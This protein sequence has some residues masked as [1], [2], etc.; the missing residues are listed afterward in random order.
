MS[1]PPI[2]K[3]QIIQLLYSLNCV[4]HSSATKKNAEAEPEKIPISTQMKIHLSSRT[5]VVFA[6]SEFI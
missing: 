6:F 1:N 2:G 5:S 3:S 4:T